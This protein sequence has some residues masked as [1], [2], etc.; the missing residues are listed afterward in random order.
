M[1]QIK[2]WLYSWSFLRF[3]LQFEIFKLFKDVKITLFLYLIIK[4]LEMLIIEK[5]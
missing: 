1:L 4:I 5:L 2:A 3:V